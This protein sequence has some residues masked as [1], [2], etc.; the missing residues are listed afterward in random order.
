MLVTRQPS[1]RKF[2]HAAMPLTMLESGPRPFTLLG[3]SPHV[4]FMEAG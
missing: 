3:V 4:S 2:W 1:L